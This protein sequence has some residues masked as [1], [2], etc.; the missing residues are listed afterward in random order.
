VEWGQAVFDHN[1]QTAF[2]LEGA[3]V[4]VECETCHRQPLTAQMRLG[5]YCADC[6]KSDDVHD[7]EFGPDCARCHTAESFS[8]VRSIR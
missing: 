7:G 3:H 4:R 1:A 5:R 8:D 6:H 2:R